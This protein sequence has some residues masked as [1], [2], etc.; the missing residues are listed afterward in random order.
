MYAEPAQRYAETMSKRSFRF[1]VKRIAR[2]PAV[3]I[4]VAPDSATTHARHNDTSK[5]GLR[6]A[7][8]FRVAIVRDKA[9]IAGRAFRPHKI[10]N[11]G[12]HG[13]SRKRTL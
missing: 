3:K 6:E 13:F 9:L 7:E 10:G 8:I 12:S 2:I 5:I 11:A 4:G 1:L